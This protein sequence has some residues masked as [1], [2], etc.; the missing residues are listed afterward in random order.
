MFQAQRRGKVSWLDDCP[1]PTLHLFLMYL[2]ESIGEHAFHL[3][4]QRPH[5]RVKVA[6]ACERHAVDHFLEYAEERGTPCRKVIC[7]SN[8]KLV[9]S[10]TKEMNRAMNRAPINASRTSMQRHQAELF[11]ESASDKDRFV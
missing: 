11:A 4:V 9:V 7:I 5:P 6:A 1:T 3:F 10:K 8:S 2:L